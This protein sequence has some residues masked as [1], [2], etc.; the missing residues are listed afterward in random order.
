MS[1][2][3]PTVV[4]RVISSQST[5][6]K[7]PHIVEHDPVVRELD[8]VFCKDFKAS[9]NLSNFRPEMIMRFFTD[10]LEAKQSVV[11]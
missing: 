11:M 5:Q 1:G 4:A 7:V 6:H 2:L 9:E 10:T 8:V 3:Q